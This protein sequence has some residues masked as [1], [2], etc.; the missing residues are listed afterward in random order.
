MPGVHSADANAH[1]DRDINLHADRDVYSNP[2]I[3][4]DVYPYHYAYRDSRTDRDTNTHAYQMVDLSA[5]HGALIVGEST[6]SPTVSQGLLTA[7][8]SAYR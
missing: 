1:A 6:V 4:C 8:G 3:Y 7:G 5:Y 2:Y